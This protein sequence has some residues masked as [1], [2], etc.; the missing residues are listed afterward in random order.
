LIPFVR[1]AIETAE[2]EKIKI[3]IEQVPFCL[4]KEYPKAISELDSEKEFSK[5]D[6][7]MIVQNSVKFDKCTECLHK[8]RCPGLSKNY[9]KKHDTTDLE[10]L[11]TP[12]RK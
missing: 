12:F 8:E 2:K 4:L 11:I 1:K 10:P 6:K 7:K 9:P 5:Q 3:I